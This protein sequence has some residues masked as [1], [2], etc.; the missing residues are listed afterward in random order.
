[1]HSTLIY[2]K[3]PCQAKKTPVL[4]GTIPALELLMSKW[5]W[6]ASKEPDYAPWVQK[7][8]DCALKYYMHMDDTRAYIIVLCKC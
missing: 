4:A 6:M 7:G 3:R 1:M 2:C 8:L 5:K